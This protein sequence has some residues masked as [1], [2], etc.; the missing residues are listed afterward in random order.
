[1]SIYALS[2]KRI[3]GEMV[4]LE[5][6]RGKVLLI[7]NTATHCGFTKQYEGLQTLYAKYQEKGLEILDFP[8][9]QFAGQA[10][11]SDEE[12]SAFC[13]LTYHT[14]FETFSKIK[15]NGAQASPL[16]QYLR[17]GHAGISTAPIRWNFTKFLV[18]RD[19]T[20]VARFDSK[21]T[22]A[23]LDEEIARLL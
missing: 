14:T 23:Q 6:Y 22:P 10:P 1:M 20:I 18:G 4:S 13:S 11:E 16:Y 5:K 7:V 3:N 17:A 12:I 2:V 8:C 9:N 21:V 19:G 15:V